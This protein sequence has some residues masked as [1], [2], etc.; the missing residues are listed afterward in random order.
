MNNF[1]SP[2]DISINELIQCI[3]GAIKLDIRATML[4]NTILQY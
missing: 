2:P 4:P 1:Q 3:A